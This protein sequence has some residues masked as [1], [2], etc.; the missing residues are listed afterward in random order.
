MREIARKTAAVAFALVIVASVFAIPLG[1]GAPVGTAA[2]EPGDGECDYGDVFDGAIKMLMFDRSYVEEYADSV[3]CVFTDKGSTT[4][5]TRTDMV[6]LAESQND[7][8]RRLY[9]VMNNSLQDARQV[10]WTKAKLEIAN[11]LNNGSNASVAISEA[12]ETVKDYYAMRQMNLVH[13]WNATWA[14][15]EYINTTATENVGTGHD[16]II[17]QH[18][19]T[20]S[21]L[22]F[23]DGDGNKHA[24][25]GTFVNGT[26]F[27][28][29]YP[30][31]DASYKVREIDS[32]YSDASYNHHF[33]V[34]DVDGNKHLMD[35]FQENRFPVVIGELWQE[36]EAQEDQVTANIDPYVSEVYN[37]Y[38]AGELNVSDL[39]DPTTIAGQAATEY[40]STG[41]YSFAAAELAA[42]GLNGDVNAS[43]EVIVENTSSGNTT[44]FTGTLFYTEDDVSQFNTGQ[45]YNLSNHASPDLNGM[46]VMAVQPEDDNDSAY[47][48]RLQE[49]GD[50]FR[51]DQATNTR[52]GENMSF[53]EMQTYV[54]GESSANDLQVELQGLQD[55]RDALDDFSLSFGGIGGGLFG[56]GLGGLGT[57]AIVLV[58]ILGGVYVLA[59][60]DG[61]SSGR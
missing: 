57:T 46:V 56:G 3:D 30:Q 2:A 44:N 49:H 29:W 52:T 25:T 50:R 60:R 6:A 1:P 39:L 19:Q 32:T 34:R 8:N 54:Y 7:S 42:M 43:H 21:Q 20:D 55:L 9:Q 18:P 33:F 31:L 11:A 27:H 40:N 10:A 61:T 51:I 47:I 22:D 53:T 16:W 45:W 13:Q 26:Q 37:D 35:S 17:Y 14:N 4:P 28:Y 23:R 24:Q 59:N 58:A 12:N 15:A 41:F 5:Q 48:T 38:E 36:I